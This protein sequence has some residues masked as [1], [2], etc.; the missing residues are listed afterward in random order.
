MSTNR[1][2][3]SRHKK[4]CPVCLSEEGT[5]LHSSGDSTYSHPAGN[6][7]YSKK[8]SRNVIN[9]DILSKDEESEPLVK[10]IKLSSDGVPSA[11]SSHSTSYDDQDDDEDR[12]L[13]ESELEELWGRFKKLRVEEK[14]LNHI[15]Y[16][17]AI[18][19]F[20]KD[21]LATYL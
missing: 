12:P 3:L 15:D 6:S 11:F 2:S 5:S 14:M 16:M 19:A 4:T 7:Q 10:V 17:K 9:G 1:H 8:S 21:Y 18:N 20:N 13:T